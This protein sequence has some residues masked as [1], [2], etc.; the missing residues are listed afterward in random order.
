MLATRF[1]RG[2]AKRISGGERTI[3]GHVF[4]RQSL[5]SA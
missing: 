1:G 2:S 4:V 5:G 3:G